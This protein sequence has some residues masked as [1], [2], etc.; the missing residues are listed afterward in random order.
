LEALNRAGSGWAIVRE[1]AEE[2][3][4]YR[5][6][7]IEPIS[8]DFAVLVGD[9]IRD[10]RSSLNQLAYQL[11]VLHSGLLTEDAERMRE[12]P[13][14]IFGARFDDWAPSKNKQTELR[15]LRS[16]GSGVPDDSLGIAVRR[17]AEAI[18]ND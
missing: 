2:A 12:L 5:I 13:I 10:L 17:A 18:S 15:R 3:V 6:G 14:R 4:V 16:S 7:L 11:A 1:D 8:A 9:A